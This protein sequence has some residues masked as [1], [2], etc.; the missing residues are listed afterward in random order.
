MPKYKC[1]VTDHGQKWYYKD[2]KRITKAEGE[3]LGIPC[4]DKPQ[5]RKNS[6]R[7]SRK[8]S[9]LC[10]GVVC[11]DDQICNPASG[12]CVKKSGRVG[13]KLLAGKKS[14]PRRKS[15]HSSRRKSSPKGSGKCKG[16][17]CSSN[18]ICNPVTGKCVKRS[19]R[20]GKKLIQSKKKS[21]KKK[22]SKKSSPARS[23]N[24]IDRSKLKLRDL[25]KKVVKYLDNHRALLVV[26]GTG[27]G[28][29][30]GI[31]TPIL[32][33]DGTIK[34]VQDVKVGDQ[35]MGIDSTPRNVLSLA[36]GRE[37][38]YK[39]IQKKG[40]KDYV[41]N[42]S[43]IL[44]LKLTHPKGIYK[45]TNKGTNYIVA[46]WFSIEN[47]KR[48]T[49]WYKFTSNEEELQVRNESQKFLDTL[50]IDDTIDIPLT[51]YMKLSKKDQYMLKGF[52]VGVEFTEKDTPLDPYFLGLWLGDGC[53]RNP[54]ITNVDQE[55]IDYIYNK[56]SDNYDIRIGNDE[57][58]YHIVSK[59]IE[60]QNRHNDIRTVLQNL[61][62]L[63]N[64]HI[65][66]EYLYNCRKVRLSLLAG[67][68]DS[69]G[70]HRTG[71]CYEI[72][73]KQKQLADDIEYL[74]RSLGMNVASSIVS[75]SCEYKGETKTGQYYRITFSTS[76]NDI[77]VLLEHK[78]PDVKS[79][80]D[81]LT[82]NIDIESIGEDDYYGF[83]IDGDHRYLLG[84][85][86]VTHNTL[87]A[88]TAS[89]CYLDRN[90][91]NKVVFVGP[92]SLLSNFKKEMK[93]YGT[94][95]NDRYELYTFD[96]FMNVAKVGRAIDCNKTMLIVD[97]A[98]NLRTLVTYT[99]DKAGREKIKEGK[100]TK[101]VIDCAY[102]ADKV[103]LLTATPF[104]N[105]LTDFIPLIN[106]LYGRTLVG[107]RNDVN[108]G[109]VKDEIGKKPTKETLTT[110]RYYLKDKVDVN[111]CRDP[112]FF[113][114]RIDNVRKVNMSDT[115][116]NIYLRT[117]RGE[118]LFG[119]DFGAHPEAFYHAYRRAVNKAGPEYYTTK[120][121]DA[122]PILR[123]GK[124]LIYS[125]WVAFG[126][127]VLEKALEHE[128]IRFNTIT[129]DTK[130]EDRAVIVKNFNDD[131]F[132]TLIITK[133]GGEGLDLKGVRSVVV[134]EPPWN[135]AGL[136]QVIG[137][138]IRYKS[139]AHLPPSQRKVDVY[140]MS[141][142][143]PAK[144]LKARGS[145][146]RSESGDSILYDIIEKK[147][148]INNYLVAM[149][150]ELSI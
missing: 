117:I 113:P 147:K 104:V 107:T 19:G 76:D 127:N 106:M 84:D 52:R 41:V 110:L 102:K 129:G 143:E 61:N 94:K 131:Q 95:H 74:V 136:E 44:T 105:S 16:V 149:M 29:C 111:D 48:Q 101:A 23:G 2:G 99:R 150:Q 123:K 43:H 62:L 119:I 10:S 54:S 45:T 32:M 89:Q 11:S 87:T 82:N 55:I 22:S 116:Y 88:I 135:D 92:A 91:T 75:K 77:P 120:I 144:V 15:K 46:N 128:G 146:E 40:G 124:A 138:A 21:S 37:N 78:K 35:L 114:E 125:N 53:S 58:T 98:H 50:Q 70:W 73:Q 103:L 28:K 139:H 142:V 86:T 90:P 34:K 5:S 65:P 49:K 72:I 71:G 47:Y 33:Y 9:N 3:R 13:K 30:H 100:K 130:K 140:M 26:H 148:E 85:F 56:F 7:A 132:Q 112:T 4:P 60:G 42:K 141:L 83:V 14:S 6:R 97:E 27:C 31:D 24:C 108:I 126:V 39:I 38:M 121:K 64:K 36:R 67:L 118:V 79:N 81:L 12:K 25:Q 59:K 18:K 115:F 122:L 137:R 8:K 66:A 145:Q 20:V 109:R 68:I 63:Q 80:K 133:A 17:V 1:I 51:E 57:I 96:K 134:L 69:D 93:A